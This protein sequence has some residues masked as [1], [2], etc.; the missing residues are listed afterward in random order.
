MKPG[1]GLGIPGLAL[2]LFSKTS[3]AQSTAPMEL[4]WQAPGNC[5]QEAQVKQKLRDFLGKSAGDVTPSR[6]RVEGRIE[7][8]GDRFRLTLS[9]HYD[10]VNGTRV[11]NAASCEDLGGVAAITLALLFRAEHHSSAPLTERDLGGASATV[12]A[13]G[14]SADAL[15]R[16]SNAEGRAVGPESHAQAISPAAE[17]LEPNDDQGRASEAGG[18]KPSTFR[19]TFRIPELRA[20][21][22]VFPDPSFGLGLAA[23]LRHDAWRFLAAATFWLAQ[24]HQAGPFL[25]YGAHFGRVSSELSGCRGFRLSEF[26]LS[27]CLLLSLDDVS[28]RAT[29]LGISSA[30]SR[31]AWLS[32]G[33]GFQGLWALNH[34]VN[35]VFGVNARV[36]TSRP[37]FISNGIGEGGAEE[38]FQVGPAAFGVVLGCEWLL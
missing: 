18:S 5:P 24:D 8:I 10:L 15:D 11:V 27:P 12:G 36:P 31:T 14:R 38:I 9:I 26:E 22:G 29:G 30:N 32:A 2:L 20:E 21:L 19:F 35:F 7:P 1:A 23:G 34:H 4:T 28:A 3:A 17:K 37:R 6:L 33:A 13:E 16:A 25:G